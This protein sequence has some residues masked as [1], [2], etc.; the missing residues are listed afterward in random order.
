M[1][2]LGKIILH[3]AGY[4]VLYLTIYYCLGG[5]IGASVGATDIKIGAGK[6][7]IT[8]LFGY[9]IALTNFLFKS[10]KMKPWLS[11]LLAYGVS[12]LAFF[13]IIILVYKLNETPARVFVGLL[14][15]TAFYFAILG[16]S[17]LVRRTLMADGKNTKKGPNPAKNSKK[18]EKKE[19][20]KPRYK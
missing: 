12:L 13:T 11:R 5:M 18:E 7:F 9:V 2:K 19:A 16:I 3:G 1:E 17:A 20:Y 15:F 6:F 4:T 10:I 8:L 14:L